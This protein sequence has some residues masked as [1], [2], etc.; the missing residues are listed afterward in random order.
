MEDLVTGWTLDTLL[1]L[2]HSDLSWLGRFRPVPSLK[3][4]ISVPKPQHPRV[5]TAG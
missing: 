4:R 3:L 1:L 5:V 2:L